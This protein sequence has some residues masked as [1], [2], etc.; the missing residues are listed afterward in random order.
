MTVIV[1]NPL[2]VIIALDVEDEISGDAMFCLADAMDGYE[3]EKGLENEI[4]VDIIEISSAGVF[5]VHV[6]P[7]QKLTYDQIMAFINDMVTTALKREEIPAE[8]FKVKKVMFRPA[9]MGTPSETVEGLDELKKKVDTLW[10]GFR[11]EDM[12][13]YV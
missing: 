8:S 12:K 3:I 1:Q 10:N 6:I 7:Q 5:A 2:D 11:K 9:T 13:P 4:V